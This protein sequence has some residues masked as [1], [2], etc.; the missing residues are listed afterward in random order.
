M[1]PYEYSVEELIEYFDLKPLPIEGGVFVQTYKSEEIIPFDALP[2]RYPQ[3]KRHF[4]TAILYLF[5]PDQ[6]SFSALHWLPT[7]E[8]YH[9]Y[10]GDPVEMLCI[11]PEGGSQRVYLGQDFRNGQHIQYV[12]PRGWIQGSHL[13]RGGR[14][15]LVGTTMAPGFD[16][17]DYHGCERQAMLQKYPKEA[18][19]IRQLTRPGRSLHM[20]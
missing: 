20:V 14:F 1:K 2:E 6:D 10:L 3:V 7:D 11:D 5:T 4:G 17:T 15:A 16:E 19:L 13:K 18:E 9:F 8:I 12:V